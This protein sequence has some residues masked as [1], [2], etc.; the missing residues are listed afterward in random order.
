MFGA[1][2][3]SLSL[4]ACSQIMGKATREDIGALFTKYHAIKAAIGLKILKAS[5][6]KGWLI[7]PLLQI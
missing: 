3:T 7:A 4:I 1:A 2:D 5:K 6:E